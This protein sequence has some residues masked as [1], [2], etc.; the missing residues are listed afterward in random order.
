MRF[1]PRKSLRSVAVGAGAA[2]I[3]AAFPVALSLLGCSSPQS[4]IVL[5]IESSTEAPLT[6]VAR[7]TVVVS[8]GTTEM[9]TL[10]YGASDLTVVADADTSSG[11]LSVSFSGGETGDIK[12]DVTAFDAQGCD[13]G[14]GT[15]IVTIKKGAVNEGILALGT[16]PGCAPDGGGPDAQ[17]GGAF[18]GCDPVSPQCAANQTCQVDCTT[19][20]NECATGGTAVAGALCQSA[21]DCA[22]GTQCFDFGNVGCPGTKVCLRFC[23]GNADCAAFGS[24]GAGPGSFCRDP[25]VCTTLATSYHTCTFN[26]DPT[27]A[28]A[29]AASAGC[30]SGLACLVPAM[31]EVD[32]ACPEKTRTGHAGDFCSSSAACAPGFICNAQSC[33]AVC[34]CDAV[35]GECTATND[36]PTAG[37]R[38]TVTSQTI[39]GICL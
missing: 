7:L 32:C 12:L 26:C 37:T 35:S 17:D 1:S 14:Q 4:F 34:R 11:T 19:V 18:G 30:P 16:G 21:S 23:G 27:A 3:L 33:R 15:V 20:K 10:T 28:A 39:Y 24:G 6:G 5:V 38:C 22:P 36:C 9:K 13:I 29:A 31:D 25:V 8:K 2:A